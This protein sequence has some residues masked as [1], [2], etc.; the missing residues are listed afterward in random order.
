M[1]IVF[2]ACNNIL[3]AQYLFRLND[4]AEY[5]K[6]IKRLSEIQLS[7]ELMYELH[8]RL[9][10]NHD[11][12][13]IGFLYTSNEFDYILKILENYL[14]ETEGMDTLAHHGVM[15]LEEYLAKEK[16]GEIADDENL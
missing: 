8:F 11:Y 2:D 4:R 13:N 14:D 6:R 9:G 5:N 3:A 16:K 15:S 1:R 7:D 10:L 12:M